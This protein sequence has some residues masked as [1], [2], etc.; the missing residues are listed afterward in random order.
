MGCRLLF[1][2]ILEHESSSDYQTSKKSFL[3]PAHLRLT[4]LHLVKTFMC[5]VG[6][7]RL[8][9]KGHF[10]FIFKLDILY[11]PL[12]KICQASLFNHISGSGKKTHPATLKSLIFSYQSKKI[13]LF[14]LFLTL[15]EHP[16]FDF[17]RQVLHPWQTK[18]LFHREK[19]SEELVTRLFK[20]D[21]CDHE[22]PLFQLL[23]SLISC[24]K[25]HLQPA[26]KKLYL[27]IC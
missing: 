2:D 14:Q 7:T 6:K 17:N 10:S 9:R 26:P 11:F 1:L 4:G 3:A 21:E 23:V 18:Q 15:R 13:T 19:I 16:H 20:V 8:V 22:L 25:S 5:G 12:W 27:K 24:S